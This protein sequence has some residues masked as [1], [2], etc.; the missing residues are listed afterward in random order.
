MTERRPSRGGAAAAIV[1]LAVSGTALAGVLMMFLAAGLGPAQSDPHG[2]ARIFSAIFGLLVAPVF[3]LALVLVFGRRH[4]W[5]ALVVSIV[6]SLVALGFGVL[7]V[8]S[9]LETRSSVGVNVPLLAV[10][11]IFALLGRQRPLL[12]P[13]DPHPPDEAGQLWHQHR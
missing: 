2:Y 11:C 5:V 1:L 4:G 10:G 13:G 6:I 9:A 7:L 8:S 12:A 3:L